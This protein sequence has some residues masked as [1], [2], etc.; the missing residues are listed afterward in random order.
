MALKE[1]KAAGEL[2]LKLNLGAGGSESQFLDG[3]INLDRKTGGEAY[4]LH[5]DDNSLQIIR[6]SHLLEH[7]PHARAQ[8]IVDHWVSKLKPGG[9]LQIAV[10][11][12]SYI[13]RQYLAKSPEP[14]EGYLMGGQ[15][16]VDDYHKSVWDLDKLRHVLYSAGLERLSRWE[17]EAADCAALPVSL[18]LQGYKPLDYTP[19]YS[20]VGAVLSAPRFAPTMHAWATAQSFGRLGIDYYPMQGAYWHQVLTTVLEKML[21]RY[22][23]IIT[24]DYDSAFTEQYVSELIRLMMAYPEIDALFPLQ[25][26]RH[27]AE[28]LGRSDEPV[29]QYHMGLLT[30]PMKS[31]HFGL[32]VFRASSLAS[33]QKP[34][35]VGVPDAENSYGEGKTDP[36]IWFWRNWGKSKL[37]VHMATGVRIGHMQEMVVWPGD[38]FKPVYQSVGD[39]QKNGPPAIKKGEL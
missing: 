14:L 3:F 25:Y 17:S 27:T 21:P 30:V 15:V 2:V 28:M 4:P 23:Y 26:K 37:S 18:N 5:Y 34:W 6:A 38:D 19:D 32:T 10:P 20:T 22:D 31:G 8:E 11:D 39:Y 7:F 36:D 35:F 13:V 33:A 9:L 29:T 1:E 16:D 12:F 24:T